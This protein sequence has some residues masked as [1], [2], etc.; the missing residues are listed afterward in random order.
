M[1]IIC[2]MVQSYLNIITHP[3]QHPHC[4]ESQKAHFIEFSVTPSSAFLKT[5]T[6]VLTTVRS[7]FISLLS[8]KN[9]LKVVDRAKG[10]RRRFLL[11]Q[12]LTVY[13]DMPG[14]DPSTAP[15]GMLCWGEM[16]QLLPCETLFSYHLFKR[17]S[18]TE[19][20]V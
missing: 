2:Y 10:T 8:T 17:Q 12:V 20:A 1:Q 7:I 16:G 15:G 5:Q 6:L 13:K 19:Q 3:C 9:V 4:S 14:T 18:N 11:P